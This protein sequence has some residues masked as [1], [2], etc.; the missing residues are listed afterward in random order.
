MLS[1]LTTNQRDPTLPVLQPMTQWN[2]APLFVFA[3]ICSLNN[4][5]LELH[6][7]QPFTCKLLLPLSVPLQDF[8]YSLFASL[9]AWLFVPFRGSCATTCS[10]WQAELAEYFFLTVYREENSQ[11][12]PCCALSHL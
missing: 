7:V 1:G 6:C 9:S 3:F 5:A 2:M 4:E 12:Q 10:Y 8:V 11:A